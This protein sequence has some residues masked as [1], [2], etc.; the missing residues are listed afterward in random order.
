[1]SDTEQKQVEQK[2]TESEKT[3]S[4]L[5][6]NLAG[7]LA[8]VVGWITGVIFFLIEKNNK[9]VRFHALQSILFNVAI[10]I[11]AI[12]VWGLSLGVAFIPLLGLIIGGLAHLVLYL[13]TFILWI[14]LMYKAYKGQTFKLPVIGE[15]AEKNVYGK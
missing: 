9:Y 14:V 12:A 13:G 5:Q 3:I 1:M 10:F 15:I 11:L 8:Y 2:Q 4:G 6:P 7:A